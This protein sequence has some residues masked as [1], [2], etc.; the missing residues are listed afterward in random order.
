MIA[1]LLLLIGLAIL[2]GAR[3]EAACNVVTPVS[4][5]FAQGTSY[6]V[7]SAS[8]ASVGSGAGFAC[9]GSTI[10][11]IGTNT[12]KATVTSANG[13]RLSAGGSDSVTYKVSADPGA[14]VT[15]TQGGTVDYMSSNVL[16]LVNILNGGSFTPQ[17]YFALTNSPN[18]AAGTY[19]D[20]I[21]VSWTWNVCHLLGLNLAGI[22][23][24]V[25]SETGTSSATIN[26]TLVVTADC[27]ISAPNISFGSAPL[28]SSFATVSQA[29]AL[30][31]TK[32]MTYKV[33]FTKGQSGV[34]RPWRAMTDGAGHSL[35]YNLYRSDGTTIWD[36]TNPLTSAVPGTGATTPT[37]MQT[38][39]AAINPAQVTP[40]AG[41]YTDTLSV[42]VSF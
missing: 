34:S 26:V 20:T 7:Q 40:P 21:T 8:V 35:Q 2:G 10:L 1:R 4:A 39:K 30:D 14:T 42:L 28:A 13:F 31:C 12:A 24:C 5:N 9:S 41:H 25:G 6:D 17:M 11:L 16:G 29:V 32:G 3:A 38:Y 19:T 22:S 15:F 23:I 37:Q 36:D 18:I 33:S 27:R